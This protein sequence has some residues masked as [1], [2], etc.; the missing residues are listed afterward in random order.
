MER[1]GINS[2]DIPARNLHIVPPDL[3]KE[4]G[5]KSSAITQYPKQVIALNASKVRDNAIH[6]GTTI[7]HEM[8]HLKGHFTMEVNKSE[9]GKLRKTPYREGVGIRALQEAGDNDEYYEHFRG[10]HEAIVAS[11]EKKFTSELFKDKSVEAE[12]LW[13]ESEKAQE[14]KKQ[15][16][17]K[18]DIPEDEIL[19]VTKD[20]KDFEV[21]GYMSF[22]KVFSYILEE[23]KNQFPEQF[24]TV[25]EVEDEFVRAHFTGHL[26]GIA[27]LI[28]TTFGKGSFRVVGMINDKQSSIQV[29][30]FLKGARNRSKKD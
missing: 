4:V 22:R 7:F 20:G 17:K 24:N 3:Y 9:D 23:I 15:I 28:E 10:L 2:F 1:L 21:T 29:L 13:M 8:L 14:I 30:K 26:V 16:S 25:D 11:Q 18:E 27:K 19:Y 5:G 6:L 12:Q